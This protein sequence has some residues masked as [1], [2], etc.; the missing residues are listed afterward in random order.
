[1]VLATR[2]SAGKERQPAKANPA[3]A[4]KQK[5]NILKEPIFFPCES[6]SP[7]LQ[8]YRS[9]ARSR[10]SCAAGTSLQPRCSGPTKAERKSPLPT[11]SAWRRRGATAAVA[12]GKAGAASLIGPS[13]F[14]KRFMIPRAGRP[15]NKFVRACA[16]RRRSSAQRDAPDSSSIRGR[17]GN[18]Y[19]S[20]PQ[21]LPT[22]WR[23]RRIENQRC[24][25]LLLRAPSRLS[26][27]AAASANVPI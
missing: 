12:S 6:L 2:D 19:L 8:R 22:P 3:K 18:S 26:R 4:A 15:V 1:M 17:A 23:P 24:R 9:A 27:S 5:R 7:P 11:L 20:V 25:R 10:V 14:I 13:S 16:R 21:R